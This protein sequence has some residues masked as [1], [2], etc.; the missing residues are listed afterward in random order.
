[1]QPSERVLSSWNIN[2]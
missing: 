1:M 2:G